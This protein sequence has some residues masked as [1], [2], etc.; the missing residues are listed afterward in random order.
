MVEWL[1]SQI[2]KLQRFQPLVVNE[3][4]ETRPPIPLEINPFSDALQN[5]EVGRNMAADPSLSPTMDQSRVKQVKSK[6]GFTYSYYFSAPREHGFPTPAYLWRE[7]IAALESP[8]PL[9]YDG[10]DK[11]T[12]P[13]FYIGSGLAQDAIDTLDNEKI[14]RVITSAQIMQMV[15]YDLLAYMGY[16]IQPEA[17]AFIEKNLPE[18]WKDHMCTPG[19]A[20]AWIEPNKTEPVPDKEYYRTALLSGGMTAPLCWYKVL[21]EKCN[22]EDDA[23]RDPIGLPIFGDMTHNNKEFVKGTVTRKEDHWAV[24]S[25]AAELNGMLQQWIEGLN[26]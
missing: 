1:R 18:T 7:Q 3:A 14:D 6:R 15:G 4:F 8:P 5:N 24:V 16:F 25:H 22:H 17:P 9:G 19:G 10:T 11:P 12:D 20:K 2:S 21:V 23:R 13:K 26:I